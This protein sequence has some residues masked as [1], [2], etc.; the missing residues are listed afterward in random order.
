MPSILHW[1]IQYNYSTYQT[2][3]YVTSSNTFSTSEITVTYNKT[4]ISNWFAYHT[5][6]P[7]Q[8]KVIWTKHQLE[9]FPPLLFSKT[10]LQESSRGI[11]TNW[12]VNPPFTTLRL[13][14]QLY[15]SS[16][17]L[18][19]KKIDSSQ[20]NYPYC[21]GVWAVVHLVLWSYSSIL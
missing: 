2:N 9:E 5:L 4:Q 19:F 3:N 8:C 6:Q 16:W 12:A 7:L 11:T 21:I 10:Y 20:S 1:G 13:P 14:L 17:M 18:R 15:T